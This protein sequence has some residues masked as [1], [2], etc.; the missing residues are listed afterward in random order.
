MFIRS[1]RESLKPHNSSF[2]GL[3][4]MDNLLKAHS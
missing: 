2:L 3:D 4:R 1:S